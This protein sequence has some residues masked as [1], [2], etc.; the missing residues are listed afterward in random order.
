M[1]SRP[2]GHFAQLPSLLEDRIL[3]GL[4]LHPRLTGQVFHGVDEGL[5]EVALDEGDCVAAHLTTEALEAPHFRSDVKGSRLLLVKRA[6]ALEA[7]AGF[8]E[9]DVP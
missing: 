8:L 7:A 2:L 3:E 5:S 9:V 4:E 1:L 6:A